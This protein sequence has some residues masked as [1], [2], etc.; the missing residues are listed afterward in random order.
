MIYILI[1]T[2]DTLLVAFFYLNWYIILL[3]INQLNKN[4]MPNLIFRPLI[5]ANPTGQVY[6]RLRILSLRSL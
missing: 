2:S 5:I 4:I 1:T 3:F 6:P